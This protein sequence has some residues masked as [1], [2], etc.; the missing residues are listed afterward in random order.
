MHVLSCIEPVPSLDIYIVANFSHFLV[1]APY[2]VFFLILDEFLRINRSK[3]V[4]I[5]WLLI[6]IVKMR[7]G[8]SGTD[9]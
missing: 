1:V 7:L 9:E 5:L 3:S 6:Y 4:S 8:R 2:L